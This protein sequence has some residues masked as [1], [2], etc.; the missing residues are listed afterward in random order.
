[1]SAA[2]GRLPRGR[3]ERTSALLMLTTVLNAALGLGFW[4]AAARLYEADTVGLA[5][6]AISALTLVSS[7]GWLGLQHVLLRYAPIAGGRSRKLIARVYQVALV[8]ALASAA[9]FLGVLSGPL[10]AEM[11][12]ASAAAIAA[13]MAAVIAWV[14]FSLQDPVLIALDREAWVPAENAIFG[15]LKLIAIVALAA[16]GVTSAWAIFGAWAACA[17]LLVVAISWLLVRRVLPTVR[18]AGAALPTSQRIAR[19]A[20]GHHVVA[21]TAALP[22]LLVP[23]LVLGLLTAD[24]TAH[25]YAAFTIS[26]AMRLLAV[27]I[28][29][30]LTVEGARDQAA[31]DAL[32]RRVARLVGVLLLPLALLV[33]LAA[34]PLLALFGGGYASEGVVLLRLF[35]I[36]LPLSAVIV[37]GLAIERVRQRSG[38]AFAVAFLATVTTIGLDLWLLPE[39]GIE[40]AGLAWLAGQ[41]LGALL[42]MAVVLRPGAASAGR[43]THATIDS[44]RRAR[45]LVPVAMLAGAVLAAAGCVLSADLELDDLGLLHSLNPLYL[46]ALA[47]LPL[48]TALE[49]RRPA[50]R[51]W[52]LAVPVLAFVLIVW[53]TP[54]VLEGT[55]RFRTS[56]Q[57]WNYVDP[58]LRGDGLQPDRL[59]Y[60]NWPLFPQLF[61]AFQ[62]VTGLRDTTI[63]AA[64]PLVVMLAWLALTVA[65]VRVLAPDA[66]PVG[67]ALGAWALVVFSWTNQDYFSPQAVAFVLF[68][69]LILVLARA[70]V[71]DGGRLTPGR[72]AIVIAL[73]AAIVVT[74]ALTSMIVLALIGALT[75]TRSVR[76]PALILIFA[77]MFTIWQADFADPFYADYGPRLRETLLAAGDFLQV[78]A[79]GRVSGSAEHVTVTRVR[80][81]VSLAAFGLGAVA[82]I[83]SRGRRHEPA[84]RF[85]V[86]FLIALAIVTPVASYGG[87]MLIRSLLF[88][89]PMIVALVVIAR[90]KGPLLAMY[91]ALLV[92]VAP[93]HIVAHYGN[94]A[95]D[96]VSEEEIEGFRFVAE[97]LAPARIY[98]GY[99]AGAFVRS[100]DLQWRNGVAPNASRPPQAAAFLN[101]RAHRWEGRPAPTYVALGRGDE[102]AAR[103]FAN[104]PD[105]VA[106]VREAIE[107]RPTEFVRV[108]SN[109]D[110]TV[111]RHVTAA[112]PP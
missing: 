61:A 50:P 33:A 39:R 70:A 75:I 19:F 57:S 93:A 92:V 36:S 8:V 96:Y 81:L 22:D 16:S 52:L 65:L 56:F 25:Y 24:A 23:L 103:M 104:R 9:L 18:D 13:F 43:T 15:L 10:D 111:W 67:W 37:I 112:D 30:A 77:L 99:P 95:Y 29:S 88:A 51:A 12:S 85:A 41:A 80:I 97:R 89:L 28:A 20:A 4:L 98:G 91:V 38:R 45:D 109:R 82:A 78:N 58:L 76:H 48:V 108:F 46:L 68:L 2:A 27:N 79:A 72:A 40:G 73:Y 90:P 110:I 35:A 83:V 11:L 6:G 74:H 86:T 94:E 31:L 3:L 21:V 59:V 107:R 100:S 71:R 66:G 105:F 101:P 55:P 106:R 26:Y 47:T 87:E 63:M 60:H 54:L 53:L 1:V 42:T 102:A 17:A 32:L 64:F 69:G 84:W 62:Q 14:M 44:S 34:D 49:A 7:F 5:A